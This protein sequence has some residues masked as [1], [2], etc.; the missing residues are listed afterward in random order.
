[1]TKFQQERENLKISII[2]K[3]KQYDFSQF[4]WNL[5]YEERSNVICSIHG[6]QHRN[7]RNLREG[8]FCV[9]CNKINYKVHRETNESY[10]NKINIKFPNN[11]LIWDNF[12][13][14]KSQSIH[15]EFH[16]KLHGKFNSTPNSAL[17]KKIDPCVEC[18]NIIKGQE[19]KIKDKESFIKKAVE[20]YGDKFLYDN[21]KYSKLN[22]IV[23]NIYCREH[24]HYFN[25]NG[26][27][28]IHTAK[29]GCPLCIQDKIKE[30]QRIPQDE[31]IKRLYEKHGTDKFD[32]TKSI[33]EG[34]DKTIE[35]KCNT[36]D[37]IFYPIV[38]NI[39]RG[40][41]CPHCAELAK[42]HRWK[43]EP[44]LFYIIKF[45]YN[46][47][48]LYK[49]GITSRDVQTRYKLDF[50]GA[51]EIIYEKYF[52]EG[53]EPFTLE[54]KLRGKIY[55]YNYKGE[56]PYLKTGTNEVFKVNPLPYLYNLISKTKAKNN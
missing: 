34:N 41:G 50:K 2:E 36:C 55:K 29:I 45:I 46:N 26:N 25:I 19:D 8:I 12:K 39:L 56:S 33:Y 52:T 21:I 24:N 37:T 10:I 20:K 30:T 16:C 27:S 47:Q 43:D 32:F 13:Y 9:E 31:I 6:V 1:M 49:I 7:I 14:P 40:T 4:D 48:V 11:N 22:D 44:T 54:Q 38:N 17:N 51:Y 15:T 53:R 18:T 23:E 5:P 3:N 35:V 28:F 42:E